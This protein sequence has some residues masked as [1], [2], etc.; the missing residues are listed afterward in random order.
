MKS[1]TTDF[2]IDADD[3]YAE[4][5]PTVDIDCLVEKFVPINRINVG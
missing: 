3:L 4:I 1:D 5:H 2:M